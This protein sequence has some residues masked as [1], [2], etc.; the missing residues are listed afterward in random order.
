MGA[1]LLCACAENTIDITVVLNG[2]ASGLVAVSG[3][4]AV[5]LPWHAFV[6]GLVGSAFFYAGRRLL[7]SLHIDDPCDSISVHGFTGMWGLWAVG[8]FCTDENVAAAGHLNANNACKRG[9]QFGVQVVGS[10]GIMCWSLC[11]S[12]F[13]LGVMR[14]CRIPLRVSDEIEVREHRSAR[15]LACLSTERSTGCC[16]TRAPHG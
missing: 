9:E 8:V 14:A 16:P 10:L 15:M 4:L 5:V 6:T 13:L 7:W 1:A 2:I 3:N 11:S 12:A